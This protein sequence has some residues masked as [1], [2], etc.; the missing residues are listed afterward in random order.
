MPKAVVL[1]TGV[2]TFGKSC[3]IIDIVKKYL[4]PFKVFCTLRTFTIENT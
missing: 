3:I 4:Y 1:F 2:Y